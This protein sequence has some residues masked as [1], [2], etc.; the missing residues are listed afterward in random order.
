ML[1]KWGGGGGGGGVTVAGVSV[2]GGKCHS[3]VLHTSHAFFN[4]ATSFR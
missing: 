3:T 4:T 1:V 2:V